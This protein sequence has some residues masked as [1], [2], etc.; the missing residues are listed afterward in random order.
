M[1]IKDIKGVSNIADDLGILNGIQVTD[2]TLKD[3]IRNGNKPFKKVIAQQVETV[4]PQVVSRHTDFIPNVYRAASRIIRAQNENIK[5]QNE[6]IK[7]QNE[8][9]ISLSKKLEVLRDDRILDT[10]RSS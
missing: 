8:K 2:Y 9:I 3:K 5:Q 10:C 6:I 7:E 1:R 4:Y